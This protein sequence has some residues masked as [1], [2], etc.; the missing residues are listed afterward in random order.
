MNGFQLLEKFPDHPFD[1]IFITAYDHYAIKAI[2]YSALDYLLKPID[3][4]ELKAAVQR[5][6]EKQSYKPSKEIV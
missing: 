6:L 5:F 4:E 1:V 2:R 3:T